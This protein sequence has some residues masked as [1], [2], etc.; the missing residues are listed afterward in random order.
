MAI[1]PVVTMGYGSF[2]SVNLLP[3]IGYSIGVVSETVI[4]GESVEF[5]ATRRR[6]IEAMRERMHEAARASM[7]DEERQPR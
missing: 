6:T 1:G 3:T 2:G 7:L 5:A 4:F